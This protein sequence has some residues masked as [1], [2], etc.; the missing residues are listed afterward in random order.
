[1]ETYI[2]PDAAG[3]DRCAWVL[4]RREMELSAC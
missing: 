1:M 3:A 2:A 4:Q